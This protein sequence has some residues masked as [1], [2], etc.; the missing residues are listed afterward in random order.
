MADAAGQDQPQGQGRRGC[1]LRQLVGQDQPGT[2]MAMA[3]QGTATLT[4]Q[5][6][7]G[8]KGQG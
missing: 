5:L 1:W 7:K 2:A 3:E 6:R 8:P 4:T